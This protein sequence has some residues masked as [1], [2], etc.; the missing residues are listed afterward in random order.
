MSIIRFNDFMA[1]KFIYHSELMINFDEACKIF[2]KKNNIDMITYN[3]LD[4]VQLENVE[5]MRTDENGHYFYEFEPPRCADIIDNIRID[6]INIKHKI[7][8]L[9]GGSEYS[10]F[11]INEFLPVA[12]IYFRFVI[13]IIFLEKPNI[14]D[15]IYIYT[16]SYIMNE[17]DKNILKNNMVLTS[18]MIYNSGMCVDVNYYENNRIITN[19]MLLFP[20][21]FTPHGHWVWK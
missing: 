16:R 17:K 7:C 6:C 18:Y 1:N 9:I 20:H 10:P 5:T 15:K 8:Y 11:F 4:V 14:D 12:A 13:K 19:N 2:D 3:N 21:G